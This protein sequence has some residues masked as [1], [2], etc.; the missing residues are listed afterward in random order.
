MAIEFA[1]SRPDRQR[2]ARRMGRA[3]PT[4]EAAQIPP[5][6]AYATLSPTE[7]F[8][9]HKARFAYDVECYPN[10]WLGS[11]RSFEDKKVI[12]FELDPDGYKINSTLLTFEVWRDLLNYMLHRFTIIGF[13]SINYDFPLTGAALEGLNT[14]ALKD[15]S[16]RIIN[17][18]YPTF[19]GPLSNCN[20]IDLIEVAPLEASLK[21]YGGRMHCQQIQELPYYHMKD[22]SYTEA[23]NVRDYN[24]NDLDVTMLLYNELEPYIKLR[25]ELGSQYGMDLRSKSDAQI[26]ETVIVSELRQ[27]GIRVGKAPKWDFGTVIKYKVPDNISFKTPKLQH[28]LEVIRNAEFVISAKG[29]TTTPEIIASLNIN[30]GRSTYRMGNGGLHSCEKSASYYSSN[31]N[32]IVDRDVASYYPFIILNQ[33]LY[34]T[35]LG[36]R[37]LDVYRSI[38][39]RRLRAKA[40]GNKIFADALKIVVNGSFGKLGSMFSKLYAPD[41]LTQVTVSGQLYL[42]MQIEE[43]EL[44][45]FN[46][47]SANTDGIV[48][49]VP[50]ARYTAFENIINAWEKR[51]GFTTEET[52]YRSIHS[53]DVNNYIAVKEDGNCKCKGIYSETG[54]ALN[55]VLSKNPESNIISDAVQ[56]YIANGTKLRDTV[57]ACIDIRRFISLRTVKGG[58]EKSGQ[59]LGKAIRWYYSTE[60]KGTINY[61]LSG[62]NV[63]KSEAAQPCLRLPSSIPHDLDYNYYINEAYEALKDVGI[64]ARPE[65]ATLF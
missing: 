59:Y 45:G 60:A 32:F 58:A 15:V 46:V 26:A 53:R 34:P 10:Y 40:A 17:K 9:I 61:V 43:L 33:Q 54:S 50:K 22:L 36:E 55:S 29:A 3:T 12:Y 52:R 42:L 4:L 51:T 57:R 24:I 6:P 2:R 11:F 21:I 62:D 30:I 19:V 7:L 13:N 31:E 14:S 63:P 16:N 28:V 39:L 47:I 49:V 8:A 38:V 23:I 18:D 44:N 35:H 56:S 48:T 1:A 64:I 65:T 27:A 41:L 25:E 37:F 5:A 20:H